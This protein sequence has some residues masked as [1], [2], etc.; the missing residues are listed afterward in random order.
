MESE[1]VP[2]R[3]SRLVHAENWTGVRQSGQGE[4]GQQ[5]RKRQ[6]HSNGSLKGQDRWTTRAVLLISSAKLE[7][8]TI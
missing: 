3:H 4:V 7:P 5:G 2:V 8:R 6:G 1:H